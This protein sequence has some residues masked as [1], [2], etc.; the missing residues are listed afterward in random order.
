MTR[1]AKRAIFPLLLIAALTVT[2]LCYLSGVGFAPPRPVRAQLLSQPSTGAIAANT[3]ILSSGGSIGLA[4]TPLFTAQA[5]R[6]YR[7]S[8]ITWVAIGGVG[9]SAG[10]T[11]VTP[12]ITF[13]TP[14]GA[15]QSVA[16][17]T[18][19]IAAASVTGFRAFNGNTRT[20]GATDQT[21]AAVLKAGSVVSYST[22]VATGIT[23]CSQVPFYKVDVTLY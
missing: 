3:L 8:V 22:A 14:D 4:S 17:P 23:G 16:M 6:L 18:L 13:V 21:I 19:I 20:S 10:S 15:V 9:C 7:I 1:D 11:D 2:G 12:T 5:Q